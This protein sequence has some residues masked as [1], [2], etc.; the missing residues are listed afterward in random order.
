MF[1]CPAFC[2]LSFCAHTSVNFTRLLKSSFASTPLLMP[3]LIYLYIYL[4][5][6]SIPFHKIVSS[7]LF[8]SS[9]NMASWNPFSEGIN[10]FPSQGEKK[11]K[12]LFLIF[13]NRVFIFSFHRFVASNR[14]NQ[15]DKKYKQQYSNCSKPLENLLRTFNRRKFISFILHWASL[16]T[17]T[18]EIG[19]QFDFSWSLK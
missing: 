10:A 8:V 14:A 7:F 12:Y 3:A 11:G 19:V 13:S 1:A 6:V 16:K 15:I 4:T 17:H 18:R 5:R 9:E 2:S